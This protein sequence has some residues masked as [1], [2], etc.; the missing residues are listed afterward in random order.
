M[1]WQ[2]LVLQNQHIFLYFRVLSNTMA[3]KLHDIVCSMFGK[4]CR[5]CSDEYVLRPYTS[6]VKEN[7]VYKPVSQGRKKS[8]V[9]Q[10][11]NNQILGKDPWVS[12]M[13]TCPVLWSKAR[14]GGK[15]YDISKKYR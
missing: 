11:C 4:E 7:G 15:K 8:L 12:E 14:Y 9:G 13:N 6:I 5:H 3:T 2:G 10:I 1:V